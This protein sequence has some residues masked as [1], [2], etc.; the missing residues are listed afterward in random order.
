MKILY[1]TNHLEGTDGWSR[2]GVTLIQEVMKR[3]H[4]VEIVM[5]EE[6]ESLRDVRA[7]AC[8]K[9]YYK[10]LANPIQCFLSARKT[11]DHIRRFS[12]DIIHII[13]EPYANILPFLHLT[14]REKICITIHGTFAY[15]PNLLKNRFRKYISTVLYTYALRKAAHIIAVSNYT[16]DYFIHA[17]DGKHRPEVSVV[18]NWV[19]LPVNRWQYAKSAIP[20]ILFV[21]AIKERKGIIESLEA[22]KYYYDN[23]SKNF[24]YIAIGSFNEDDNYFKELQALIRKHSLQRNVRFLGKISDDELEKYYFESHLFMMLPVNQGGSFEGFGLVYLEANAHG[25]PVLGGGEAD[26]GAPEAIA[27]G[28]SGFVAR[29]HDKEKISYYMDQILN[30]G[31][32]AK[33]DCIQW[34]EENRVEKKVPSILSIYEHATGR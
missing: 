6:N 34:A 13:V 12:P 8:L 4:E 23:Y 19:R 30:R 18:T 33:E 24:N 16:K 15:P 22:L 14:G 9:S 1:I 28:K 25:L 17:V 5:G 27:R 3:G 7:T 2:Y 31:A 29:S 10:Y 11:A 20:Q 26:S 32:I 21:G